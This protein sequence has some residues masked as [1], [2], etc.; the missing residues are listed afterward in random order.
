[1]N[2]HD[3]GLIKN[4]GRRPLNRN[5]PALRARHQPA[6]PGPTPANAL[7]SHAKRL[8]NLVTKGAIARGRYPGP[9]WGAVSGPAGRDR[10][11]IASGSGWP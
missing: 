3:N 5:L 11:A 10:P 9:P 2:R 4:Q 7:T 8:V 1:M 6:E